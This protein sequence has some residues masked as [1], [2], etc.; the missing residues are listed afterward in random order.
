MRMAPF[1]AAIRRPWLLP[2]TGLTIGAAVFLGGLSIS[3]LDHQ[4][5]ATINEAGYA[6]IRDGMTRA[7]VEELLGGPPRTETNRADLIVWDKL[8]REY[9]GVWIIPPTFR[10]PQAGEPRLDLETMRKKGA[11]VCEDGQYLVCWHHDLATI[12]VVFDATTDHVRGAGL[13]TPREKTLRDYPPWRW[14]R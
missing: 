5:H 8:P 6:Q 3:C 4:P 11:D 1:L 2:L 12:T 7:E 13:W 14:F 9:W 10:S